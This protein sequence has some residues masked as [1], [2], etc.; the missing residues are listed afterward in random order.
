EIIRNQAHE[1]L[2][3]QSVAKLL[4]TVKKETP[5]VVDELIPSQLSIGDLQKILQNLLKEH[6]P[7]RD[8]EGI[9]EAIADH[10]RETKDTQIL[11]EYARK[12]LSRSI[13]K[14]HQA[15]DGKVYAL[16]LDPK[17]E[18]VIT[19]SIQ[20]TEGGAGAI[21]PR[22]VQQMFRSLSTG[23]EK[24]GSQG[25]QPLVL[26]SPIVRPYFKKMIERFI[27]HLTVLSFSELLPR[28]EIQSVATIEGNK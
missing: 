23:I 13:T 3:R 7:I 1:F 4:E 10:V 27:P 19:D 20:S 21:D 5:A 16:T 2:T 8:L 11:T 24:M 22:L 26:C 18:K 15:S 6:L 12:S 9:L 14:L 25:R 17:F 28:T